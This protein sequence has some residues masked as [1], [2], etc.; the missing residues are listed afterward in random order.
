MRK[1]MLAWVCALGLILG[2][3][4]AHAIAQHPSWAY[5]FVEL[6]PPGSVPAAY[7]PPPAPAAPAPGAS[8]AQWSRH[9]FETLS[10]TACWVSSRA[11]SRAADRKSTRLNSSHMSESRMPSSA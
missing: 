9:S 1:T 8:S 4:A 10:A 6:P 5:G 11:R 7:V 3:A 2:G